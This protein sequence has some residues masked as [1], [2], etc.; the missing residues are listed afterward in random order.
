MRRFLKVLFAVVLLI[1]PSVHRSRPAFKFHG[2]D[3]SITLDKHLGWMIRLP[4]PDP[5]VDV[6]QTHVQAMYDRG[7]FT[8]LISND[9]WHGHLI[10]KPG[11]VPEYHDVGALLEDAALFVYH[12][13]EFADRWARQAPLPLERRTPRSIVGFWDGSVI[14]AINLVKPGTYMPF[15]E[16]NGTIGE[17]ELRSSHPEWF[18]DFASMKIVRIGPRAKCLAELQFLIVEEPLLGRL[19]FRGHRYDAFLVCKPD[20]RE[21]GLDGYDVRERNFVIDGL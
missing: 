5:Y 13:A 6:V 12:T 4:F 7:Y 1:A 10:M 3:P 18:E 19:T 20:P 15:Y 17:D 14:P 16:S 2:P 9:L 11:A 8:D 21:L